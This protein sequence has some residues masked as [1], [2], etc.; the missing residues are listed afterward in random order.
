MIDILIEFEKFPNEKRIIGELLMAYGEIEFAIVRLLNAYFDDDSLAA[1]VL[2]RVKGEGPR[3][4]IADAIIRH[5]LGPTGLKDKWIL[6]ISAA[7]HCKSIRNQYAHCH[8]HIDEEERPNQLFFMNLDQE[9][10]S[11]DGLLEITFCPIDLS[12]LEQHR[13]Y[14][15][16]ALTWLYY[17]DAEYRKHKGQD[18]SSILE[19]EAPKSIPQPPLH[20][21]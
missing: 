11:K 2:F 14:F 19:I 1:R 18:Q 6:A 4:D 10:A 20:N 3:L 16:Y 5:E 9:V 7:R 8:W 13:K 17:L 15:R 21:R 12:L